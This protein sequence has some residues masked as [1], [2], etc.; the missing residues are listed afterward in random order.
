MFKTTTTYQDGAPAQTK[1]FTWSYSRLKN[2][3][4]CPKKHYHADL[5][6]KGS[7]DSFKDTKGAAMEYGNQVHDA[8]AARI[9]KGHALPPAIAHFEP[10]VQRVLN[11]PPGAKLLVEQ[12]MAITREFTSTGYWDRDVWYRAKCVFVKI[13]GPV[14]LAVDWKT[15]KIIEDSE[16]LA[17][18][19]QCIFSAYPEVQKV[20]TLF[21]WLGNNAETVLDLQRSDMATL[22]R[23]LL[24]EVAGYEEACRTFTF[25]PKPSGLCKSHC[26]VTSC[27]SH[28][29]G[30]Y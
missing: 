10:R 7:P 25:P 18:M 17:L 29:K 30:S 24:P 20:R 12:D 14:A 5:A 27:P 28:G 9:S 13:V 1:P 15:G 11:S 21:D 6:P 8:I 4:T 19:A 22:W 26:P 2:Y 16:Q 23:Q 3:R